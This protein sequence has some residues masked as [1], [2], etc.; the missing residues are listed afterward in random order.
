MGEDGFVGRMASALRRLLD[1]AEADSAAPAADPRAPSGWYDG[2]GLD[3]LRLDD[4]LGAAEAGG[5]E[6]AW[7]IAL[8]VF[9]ESVGD[10]W[11][12][13]KAKVDLIVDS[14]ARRHIDGAAT[15]KSVEDG[16]Y[17]VAFKGARH[18]A[19]EKRVVAMAE[20]L[21]RHLVGDRFV[22]RSAEGP[23]AAAAGG[24]AAQAQ[25]AAGEEKKDDSPPWVVV[26]AIDPSKVGSSDGSFDAKEILRLAV[27]DP[28]F[29]AGDEFLL[30]LVSDP[31]GSLIALTF[32][33][34]EKVDPKLVA[35]DPRPPKPGAFGEGADGAPGGWTTFQGG[36]GG[37]SPPIQ[38]SA[39]AGRGSAD[40]VVSE[41]MDGA[42]RPVFVPSSSER[43]EREAGS[44]SGT[45]SAPRETSS[46]FGAPDGKE[47]GT[48]WV[49]TGGGA[50]SSSAA[51]N[52][53]SERI[54]ADPRWI[55]QEERGKDAAF[56]GGD[57][58]P[59]LRE[60]GILVGGGEEGRARP[61]GV[62]AS[63]EASAR[64][65][66][67][68]EGASGGRRGAVLV[69]DGERR[70]EASASAVLA[71]GDRPA[72]FVPVDPGGS[73]RKADPDW[74]EASGVPPGAG[75]MDMGGFEGRR[76]PV[77]LETAGPAESAGAAKAAPP[78]ASSA[79][80]DVRKP[81]E[82]SKMAS[83]DAKLEGRE[84]EIVPPSPKR[85]DPIWADLVR[86]A[87][88]GQGPKKPVDSL[89]FSLLEVS[90]RPIL[91]ASSSRT[92]MHL[93]RSLLRMRSN[94]LEDDA[95]ASAFAGQVERLDEQAFL[96]ALSGLSS[97]KEGARGVVVLPLRFATLRSS[98]ADRLPPLLSALSCVKNVSRI[99]VEVTDIPADFRPDRL[100]SVL[101]SLRPH[102]AGM[103]LR[104]SSPSPVWSGASF[105]KVFAVGFD[106]SRLD[107]SARAPDRLPSLL[108]GFR[109]RSASASSYAWGAASPA[110]AQA[111]QEAGF[112]LVSGPGVSSDVSLP[113]PPF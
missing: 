69:S 105:A 30:R 112:A 61:N 25:G 12:R 29:P 68:V 77:D 92:V 51:P 28:A 43:I 37:G 79:P 48:V 44:M 95:V 3:E 98:F 70:K 110:E 102:A 76:G 91:E 24:A 26:S 40:P 86:E 73:G 90:W 42:E 58:G 16:V 45:E 17:A 84:V 59:G 107:K 47:K 66:V 85:G 104:S 46:V 11:P 39:T 49:K 13:L 19:F 10:K 53:S 1:A 62:G 64:M 33:P 60:T 34:K 63:S 100:E 82:W 31:K 14:A 97:N 99:L 80:P 15:F 87:F 6:V 101:S 88:A 36:S 7:T 67:L 27:A 109:S 52:P 96:A 113:S 20:D 9:G 83:G 41:S 71:S 57:F 106:L 72:A 18:S 103:L 81:P 74:I 21:G 89:S 55:H 108:K 93:C 23:A 65:P 54:G 35:Q 38:V 2:S 4:V 78:A 32:E 56:A 5:D 22:G 75:A 111:V 8:R 94:L 50:A